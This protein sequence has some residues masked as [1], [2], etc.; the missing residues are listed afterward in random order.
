MDLK[1]G[2]KAREKVTG[3]EGILTGK[4]EYLYGCEQWMITPKVS[5]ETPDKIESFWFDSGRLEVIGFG[6]L[7][8]SV[9]GPKP[10]GPNH[11]APKR[12]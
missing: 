11:D 3:I 12:Y 10:G 9:M 7:P 1:L 5:K 4:A 2:L 8:K 6:V